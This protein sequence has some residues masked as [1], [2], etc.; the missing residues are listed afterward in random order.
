MH[1]GKVF[2]ENISF[3][4]FYYQVLNLFCSISLLWGP[5]GVFKKLNIGKYILTV[6]LFTI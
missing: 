2:A 6:H 5:A 3:Y 1:N 4:L